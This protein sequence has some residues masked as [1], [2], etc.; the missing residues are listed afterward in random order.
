MAGALVA[1][2]RASVAGRGGVAGE[3]IARRDVRG[4]HGHVV[5]RPR[6]GTGGVAESGL[7]T[8]AGWDGAGGGGGCQAMGMT[9]LI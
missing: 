1:K 4:C 8:V 6:G 7:G 3:E 9:G 5:R 2:G